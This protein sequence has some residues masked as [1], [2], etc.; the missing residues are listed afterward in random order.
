MLSKVAYGATQLP[1]RTV[2]LSPAAANQKVNLATYVTFADALPR[3]F[4]TAQ[5]PNPPVAATVVAEPYSLH[6]DA[7][8][9]Y[10]DPQTCDYRFEQVGDTYNIDTAGAACNVTYRRA[11]AAGAS[12]TLKAQITWRVHWTPSAN[13]DGPPA[14]PAMPDGYT[15]SPQQVAVQEIQTVNR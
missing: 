2:A 13:P 9:S 10:A 11:T 4:V 15:T 12:Y 5:V 1:T 7:G 3:V 14:D 6:I 8:T